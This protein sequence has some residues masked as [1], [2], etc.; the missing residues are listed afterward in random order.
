MIIDALVLACQ[1]SPI[2]GVVGKDA[3]RGVLEVEY[4]ELIADGSFNL[5]AVWELFEDQ[6]GFDPE[7]AIGPLCRFKTWERQLGI[8]VTLPD[9]LQKLTHSERATHAAT[10]DVPSRELQTILRKASDTPIPE[11]APRPGKKEPPR[12]SRPTRQLERDPAPESSASRRKI[13]QLAASVIAIV[14]FGIAG[15]SLYQTCASEPSWTD[16]PVAA[17]GDIPVGKAERIG[18]QVRA[19]LADNGWLG[20]AEEEQ[21]ADLGNALRQLGQ[22]DVTVL[23]VRDQ[24]GKV[25]AIAQ[26]YDNRSRMRFIFK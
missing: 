7:A 16:V 19:T 26:Y 20:K 13:I 6:P 5:Q 8:E 2:A 10:C 24:A 3:L 4:R 11:A 23:Y 14:G 17:F 21:E 22:G 9:M 1:H 12:D 25:R 18:T 15:I